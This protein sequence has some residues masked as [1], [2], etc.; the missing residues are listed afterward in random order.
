MCKNIID[1]YKKYV[2]VNRACF[3]TNTICS[4]FT[5][6]ESIKYITCTV[7]I[8][9]LICILCLY[10]KHYRCSWQR[11]ERLTNMIQ[12]IHNTT[13]PELKSMWLSTGIKIRTRVPFGNLKLHIPCSTQSDQTLFPARIACHSWLAFMMILHLKRNKE[14]FGYIKRS[15]SPAQLVVA[16]PW[17]WMVKF[18]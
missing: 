16:H 3:S 14:N 5:R 8:S 12:M 7:L 13:H 2:H 4:L 1:L 11:E 15:T 18:G 17:V 10:R 6:H 9:L